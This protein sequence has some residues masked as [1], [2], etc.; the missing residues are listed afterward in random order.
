[1][2][3]KKKEEGLKYLQMPLPEGVKSSRY[4]KLDWKGLSNRNIHDSGY[5]SKCENMSTEEYPCLVT[6]KKFDFPNIGITELSDFNFGLTGKEDFIAT[7]IIDM[8]AF[9]NKLLFV[10]VA[11][12]NSLAV[13][14]DIIC[15][16]CFNLKG[17]EKSGPEGKYFNVFKAVK[18]FEKETGKDYNCIRSVKRFNVYQAGDDGTNII[19][20]NYERKILIYPD[21]VSLPFY[22]D[23]NDD[24][25]PTNI[26]T[27]DNPSPDFDYVTV[28]QSRLFGVKKGK[29]FASGFNNYANWSLDV[30]EDS[31][32]SPW[33]SATQSNS[34]SDGEFTGITTYQNH[35]ICFK[36]NF[37]QEIYNNRNPFRIVD[38]CAEG[39]VDNRSIQEVNGSLIFASENGFKVYTGGIPKDISYDLNIEKI[40]EAISVS[41]DRFY[42]TYC[43]RSSGSKNFYVYDT[44]TGFWNEY[45][46]YSKYDREKTYPVSMSKINN[47]VYILGADNCIYKIQNSNT[48]EKWSFETDLITGKTVDIKHIRKLQLSVDVG[49]EFKIYIL[50]DNESFNSETSHLAFN[51]NGRAG[52]FPV[53]VKPRNTANYGFKLHIEGNGYI[54]LHELEI[55]VIPGGELLK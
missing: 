14:E 45:I 3:K 21:C 43:I 26:S 41:D 49:G 50:Y 7:E 51:S 46:F 34:Q 37:M 35:V 24:M 23:S 4:Q 48:P 9:E 33:I 42:Y 22:V 38:I 25:K 16:A 12:D 6:R 36:K 5:L 20:S 29:I 1:M 28:H 18:D 31:S 52:S 32:N 17:S 27:E 40:E 13:R 19:N 44:V 30:E 53:R 11:Y 10:F 8:F 15:Y 54:K 47:D 39:C 55:H 2:A